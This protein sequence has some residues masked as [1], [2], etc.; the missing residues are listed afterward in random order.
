[1]QNYERYGVSMRS[2]HKTDRRSLKTTVGIPPHRHISFSYSVLR[3][4]SQL[5]FL[6]LHTNPHTDPDNSRVTDTVYSVLR[7]ASQ[8]SF[9]CL[10]A[11][12]HTDPDNSRLTDAV[13]SVLR[14]ASQLSFLCLHA[15]PQTDPDNS[16]LTD[17]VYSVLRFSSQQDSPLTSL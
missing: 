12:P 10:H 2:V 1:M 14:F 17:A 7:F 3:F 13:Y 15:N 16:R 8:L 6:C 4:A 9:L 11:N 5:S